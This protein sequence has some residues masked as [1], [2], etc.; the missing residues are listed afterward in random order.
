MAI[1]IGDNFNYQGKKPNFTRDS[2][3][4]LEAM[5][6]ASESLYDEGHLSFCEEDKKT[7]KYLSTNEDDVTTGK[8]REF[9]A[10]TPGG[11]TLTEDAIAQ[12]KIGPYDEGWGVLS[13]APINTITKDI[14]SKEVPTPKLTVKF[15]DRNG[16]DYEFKPTVGSNPASWN[17]T[18][19][20]LN[21]CKLTRYEIWNVDVDVEGNEIGTGN[22][23][24]FSVIDNGGYQG[25]VISNGADLDGNTLFKKCYIWIKYTDMNDI[26]RILQYTRYVHKHGAVWSYFL[27]T[28]PTPDENGTVK[29]GDNQGDNIDPIFVGDPRFDVKDGRTEIVHSADKVSTPKYLIYVEA[30]AGHTELTGLS[31]NGI[32]YLERGSIL[33]YPID[34][35]DSYS[36][37]AARDLMMYCFPVP[38]SSQSDII[39]DVDYQYVLDNI[40]SG[41]TTIINGG[42]GVSDAD[43]AKWNAKL[44]YTINEP[45]ESVQF[46]AG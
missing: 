26:P 34:S 16:D 37:M 33:K 21:G 38:M 8:W 44:N 35:A 11:D 13:G 14:M 42:T 12:Y 31:L 4:T 17:I 20:D 29:L 41:H 3:K 43:R 36:K 22:R 27:D 23:T 6:T 25:M 32:N 9:G 2:F 15:V 40:K 30:P 7:Y 1:I 18:V 24:G 19:D 45:A 28:L 39:L 5:R 10:G 46:T